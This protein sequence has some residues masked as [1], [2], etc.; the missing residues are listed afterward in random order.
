MAVRDISSLSKNELIEL[1]LHDQKVMFEQIQKLNERVDSL[2]EQHRK[3]QAD[4]DDLSLE[5]KVTKEKYYLLISAKYQSQR[6]KV[7]IDYPTLFNDAELEA[8][9]VEVTENEEVITIPEH[10][11]KKSHPKEKEI[12]YD[13]LERQIRVLPVPE[14][15]LK[16][17]LCG[18]TRKIK[19]YIDEERLVVVPAKVYVEVTR[20]PVLEC[21]HCQEHNKEGKSSY[22]V[23][24]HP[25]PLFK[26]SMAS[27]SMLG[28]II[29]MKYNRGLPLYTIEKMFDDLGV[30]IPRANMSN[31]IIGLK[32][33]LEPL[34]EV[35]KEDML[36]KDHL[37]ADETVTQV[38]NE[39]GK[40][41]TSK[42]YM[43]VY[44]T[45][46]G[47]EQIVL[48]DYRASRSGDG[49]REF[50]EGFHGTLTTDA[51][52]GY[53][54]VED[55]RRSMCN[56]HALRKFKDAFKLLPNNKGRL[57]SDEASAVTR[58]QKIFEEENRI[59]EKAAKKYSDERK[60]VYIQKE[61][62]RVIKPLFDAF[63]AWLEE[64]R[65]RNT[66]RYAM[67]Q[68]IGYTLGHSEELTRF[69]EDGKTPISNQ[70]CEQSIRPFVVI[71]NRC[72]FYVSPK[73]AE[74]SA[75]IYSI[76]IT[77]VLNRV[78]PYMYFMHILEQLP[79][80]DLKDKEALRAIVPYSSSLPEYTKIMSQKQIDKILKQNDMS[81]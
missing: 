68:A 63:L 54:K 9:N 72:K 42:S 28:Y 56:I 71:R 62:E 15:E 36:S 44:R 58:Y 48:Y 5:L 13:D 4:I 49:P 3:D 57:K 32:K 51:Y 61:R 18:G 30:T 6:N 14:E 21:E 73:G 39:E 59:Q 27:P 33:Y 78:Q 37:H 55:I 50:L 41:A 2:E 80:M 25:K 79:N 7:T 40:L 10:T 81:D 23:I 26:G 65:Q 29:D 74:V 47:D 66:G 16:C 35:M 19:K 76:V 53:N 8:L 46:A 75:M 64:I 52:E 22:E 38:L 17:P 34:Y 12:S 67:S 60:Y 45:V 24:D 31:W 69:I 70:A 43:F 77:A 1:Y 20:I 11:R